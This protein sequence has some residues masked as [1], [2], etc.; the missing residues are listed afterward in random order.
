VGI[1]QGLT[2][3]G[4][5]RLDIALPCEIAVAPAHET[6]VHLTAKAASANSRVQ[7]TVLDGSRG[8]LGVL[9]PVYFPKGALLQLW[10]RNR[11]Q[12]GDITLETTLR[13][14]RIVMTDRRPAYLLGLAYAD[15]DAESAERM[16][17][18]VVSLEGEV[19]A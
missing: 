18:F 14:K 8:G 7:A 10:I 2:V 3:R 4:A 9:S 17:Q 6:F 11:A 15:C 5:K 19:D 16:T 12:G 1:E 13:V